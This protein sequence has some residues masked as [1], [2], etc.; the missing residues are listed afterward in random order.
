V[1]PNFVDLATLAAVPAPNGFT[2]EFDLDGRFVVT[3]AGNLGPAQGLETLLDAARLLSDEPAIVL[4]LIGSGSL[5]AS[6]ADRIARER[7][8]NARL[9]P[10][11]PYSRV[12]EIY[13]ASDLS[14]VAQAVSTGTDAVPS[15]VYRIMACGRPVLA[16]TDPQSDLA[17]LVTEAGCGFVVAQESAADIAS[18]I[19]D[20]Y[21]RRDEL[22]GMGE[23]GRHHVH[24]RYA[25]QV[26]TSR[27]SQL[28]EELAAHRR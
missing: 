17:H 28:V 12:P 3:Y 9:V 10:Y 14:V 19:R 1:I 13:G 23:A 5:W 25:R 18:A 16:A 24:A 21:R 6:L 15:K 20:A 22:T 7:L 11:Q 27:Y 4:A 26:V 2:H 8:T